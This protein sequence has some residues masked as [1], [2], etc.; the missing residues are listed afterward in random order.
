MTSFQNLEEAARFLLAHWRDEGEPACIE[1]AEQYVTAQVDSDEELYCF[2]RACGEVANASVAA[3]LVD[4]LIEIDKDLWAPE[5]VILAVD[6]VGLCEV[7]CVRLLRQVLWQGQRFREYFWGDLSRIFRASVGTCLATVQFFPPRCVLANRSELGQ[8]CR[9]ILTLPR[10][11]RRAKH[12]RRFLFARERSPPLGSRPARLA[13]RVCYGPV[14]EQRL[15]QRMQVDSRLTVH[16]DRIW[17]HSGVSFVCQPGSPAGQEKTCAFS[18]AKS[19]S[20]IPDVNLESLVCTSDDWHDH[21]Q[22]VTCPLGPQSF[23]LLQRWSAPF[24]CAPGHSAACSLRCPDA[25]V[26]PSASAWDWPDVYGLVVQGEGRPYRLGSQVPHKD[27][28]Y[29]YVWTVDKHESAAG[30]SDAYALQFDDRSKRSFDL[31]IYNCSWAD[32]AGPSVASQLLTCAGGPG[33]PQL[34]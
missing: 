21:S 7:S 25:P 30:T 29:E 20:E 13:R 12:S 28:R 2:L 8:A 17:P 15:K 14:C 24:Q 22:A 19:Q 10:A 26:D 31:E 18:W 23:E 4:L 27:K 5:C 34:L 1:P 3:R 32:A 9:P 16:R 33:P 6:L 11:I